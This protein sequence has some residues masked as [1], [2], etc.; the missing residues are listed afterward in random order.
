MSKIVWVFNGVGAKFPSAVFS[1]FDEA[2]L[3][4]GINMLSGVLTEYP[5]D[6][7]VYD[8][9]ITNGKFKPKKQEHETPKFIAS[10]SS[11][12]QKH[13]R[14]ENGCQNEQL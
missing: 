11:A 5:V 12:S 8:W 14:F 10:F 1:S 4:I 2:C 9:A 13:V 6:I 3:W 7:S